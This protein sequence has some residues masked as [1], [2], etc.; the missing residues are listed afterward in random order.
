MV[1]RV[2]KICVGSQTDPSLKGAVRLS[3]QELAEVTAVSC[4]DQADSNK[5]GQL[6]F[7]EF[8]SW[9]C[10]AEYE[11]LNH[12]ARTTCTSVLRHLLVVSLPV[13]RVCP[14]RCI[15]PYDSPISLGR[16]R[17]GRVC[18]ASGVVCGSPSACSG[19]FCG[20]H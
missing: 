10:G 9:F 15:V 13:E 11:H 20:R 16:F 14:F 4:F 3:A 7:D 19:S 17:H 12:I 2:D 8:Q 1:A 5:D 18:D 6:S